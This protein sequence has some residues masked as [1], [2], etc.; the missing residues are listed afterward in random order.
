ML[1][2]LSSDEALGHDGPLHITIDPPFHR[3]NQFLLN[4][5]EELGVDISP[6]YN[7]PKYMFGKLCLNLKDKYV[8]TQQNSYIKVL[9]AWLCLT[10]GRT[11]QSD[12]HY[13]ERWAQAMNFLPYVTSK[14]HNV[15][16]LHF[17]IETM[18]FISKTNH[19]TYHKLR[20]LP[21]SRRKCET[22]LSY[23]QRTCKH[24]LHKTTLV[25]YNYRGW[26]VSHNTTFPH[27]HIIYNHRV[28]INPFSV[29]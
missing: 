29:I 9:I 15:N 3:I 8:F 17:V 11:M 14:M 2:L 12:M 24:K 13:L 10:K 27:F 1:L 20:P 26:M 25:V 22:C 18:C 19:H 28:K 21:W 7:Q 4:A 5:S 6:N 23:C 16:L